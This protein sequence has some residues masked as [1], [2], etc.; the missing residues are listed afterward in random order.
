MNR[1]HD[2]RTRLEKA[3]GRICRLRGPIAIKS[4]IVK[5]SPTIGVG[6]LVLRERLAIPTHR[7]G[8]LCRCPRGVAKAGIVQRRIVRKAGRIRWRVKSD[9]RRRHSAAERDTE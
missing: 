6:V 8:R 7:A 1:D 9:V 5:R 2:G 3:D 4:E